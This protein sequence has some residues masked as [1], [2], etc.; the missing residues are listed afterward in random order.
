MLKMI[1]SSTERERKNI[2]Y[3]DRKTTYATR[4]ERK[5]EQANN[6]KF[7]FLC[8][9]SISLLGIIFFLLAVLQIKQDMKN[10]SLSLNHAIIKMLINKKQDETL[11]RLSLHQR[12]M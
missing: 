11:H 6:N 12:E 4:N 7:S 5:N 3:K 2:I 1:P 9:A 8:G 10:K